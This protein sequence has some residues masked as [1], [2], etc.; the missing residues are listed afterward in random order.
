MHT[1]KPL[2]TLFA[3]LFLLLLAVPDPAAAASADDAKKAE[4]KTPDAPKPPPFDAEIRGF[5]SPTPSR[6]PVP[7]GV[8]FVGSSSIK[9]WKNT[10]DDFPGLAV[11][12]RGFGGS[13]IRHSTLYADRIV[14]PY[15]PKT[16][17]FYP[18]PGQRHRRRP[19]AR[20]GPR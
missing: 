13:Q 17:V 12:N 18:P 20:A 16:I 5:E 15:K 19:Q 9:N 11:I 14:L 4:A 10:A 6:R 1:A 8:L 7:G 2:R 3:T